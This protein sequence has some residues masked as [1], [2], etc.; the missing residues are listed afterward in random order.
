[1]PLCVYAL[2]TQMITDGPTVGILPASFLLAPIEPH[3][4][5]SAVTMLAHI[6]MDNIVFTPGI[7]CDPV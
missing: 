1:M 4:E 3:K 6:S 5:R 7:Y 2:T